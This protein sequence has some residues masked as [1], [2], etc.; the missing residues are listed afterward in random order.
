MIRRGRSHLRPVGRMG[1]PGPPGPPGRPRDGTERGGGCC[2]QAL[3]EP[4]RPP[5]PYPL[6]PPVPPKSLEP[7]WPPGDALDPGYGDWTVGSVGPA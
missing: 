5:G 7:A 2:G 4:S 3:P 1:R 6:A